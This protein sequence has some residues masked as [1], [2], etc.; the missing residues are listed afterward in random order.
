[1]EGNLITLDNGLVV[2]V[3]WLSFTVMS[4]ADVVD[5]LDM[6]GY[7]MED[8]TRMP[9]G[10]RGYKTMFRLNGYSL[11][12]LCDGNPGMGIHIDVAGSAIGEL[13]RSFSE[14]LKINT[15]FG[16]GYDIDFD[17]T[18]M[19]ALLERIVDNGHVTRLDIA[20]DDIGCRYFSTDDVYS[21][22]SNTQ[23]VTKTRNVRNFEDWDAPGRKSGH[24]VYFGSRTS[25]IFLRVYDK[26]ME[27]NRKL[28][29]SG[30]RIDTPWTRWELELKNERAVNVVKLILSD[31][32]LGVVAV[33]V[34]SHYIRMIELDDSN[35]SR[36]SIY[37]LW[38]DFI[39]GI[40]SLKI[41]VPKF[42]KSLEDKKTWIKRQVM[43][44][45][46][47]VILADGGSLE[48]VEDNLE[49]GLNRMN[50][51]LYEMAMV[52]LGG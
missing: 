26:Q 38:A 28:V 21:L 36:C 48:F 4:T 5:V 19:K 13:V 8:F 17:G 11:S 34:L 40:S 45:L 6:F 33:G 18:F 15:P 30:S 7:V 2:S 49:N 32:S 52:E 3:D 10:A 39:N 23:I 25:D 14:T 37:P 35:R 12:V 9:R 51:S 1:M 46:A 43:P 44:T 22:Y 20:V 42:E 50:K 27:R 24:T 41:T 16:E 47:A 29:D 31:L